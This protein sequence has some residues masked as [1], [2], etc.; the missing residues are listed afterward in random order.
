MRIQQTGKITDDFYVVGNAHVPVYL[1]DGP[2]PVLFDA[3][4][5]ALATSYEQDIK[6]ILKKRT[7]AYLFLTHSHF[8]HIGAASHFKTLW[9]KMQIV[10]SARMQEILARPGAIQ[11]IKRLNREASRMLRSSGVHPT[12]D[13]DFEPVRLDLILVPDQ[14]IEPGHNLSV[15]GIGAPG[16]TWDFMSYWVA[17][18]KILLASE[19]VGTQDRSGYIF[20]EFLVDYDAY[21][22]SMSVL[23]Q[24]DA[25]ILCPGHWQVVTGADAKEYIS[26]SLE[27]AAEFAAMV[28]RFLRAEEGD[29]ERT[30]ERVKVAEWDSKPWPKQPKAAYLLNTHA[31]VERVWE[32]MQSGQEPAKAVQK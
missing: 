10:G 32:R 12:S 4:F 22:R 7:P 9:P 17:E 3:G 23:A 13:G 26:N 20:S 21:L 16:H 31:R 1:L 30:V 18:K 11:L 14:T 27:H 15:K 2:K 19:A 24:L 28:E 8:D 5:T 6:K 29:I 25:Q